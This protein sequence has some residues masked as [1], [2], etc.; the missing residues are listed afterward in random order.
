MTTMET[1]KKPEQTMKHNFDLIPNHYDYTVNNR[2]LLINQ[3]QQFISINIDL[4]DSIDETTST[5]DIGIKSDNIYIWYT[6]FKKFNLIHCS[7][8]NLTK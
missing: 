8:I 2:N 7:V 3:D 5:I 4:I 1:A 6:L